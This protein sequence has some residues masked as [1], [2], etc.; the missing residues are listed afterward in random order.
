MDSKFI[1][2]QI[3]LRGEEKAKKWI[4]NLQQLIKKYEQ[5]WDIKLDRPFPNLSFNFVAGVK[6]SNGVDAVLKIGYPGDKL[7]LAEAETLKIYNGVGSIKLLKENLEDLVLL[8]ER[9]IPGDSLDSLNDEDQETLIYTQL[10]KKIWKKAPV[11]SSFRNIS[12]ELGDFDWYFENYDIGKNIIDKQ[13]V[14]KAQEKFKH[15]ITTQ[16]D[17]VLLHSDLHHDHI[18]LSKRGWLTIDCRGAIGEKEYESSHFIRNPVK[19]AEKSMITEDI[20][21]KRVDIIVRELNLDRQ[22]VIDWAF[23]QTVLSVIWSLQDTGSGA[24]YWVEI[25]KEIERIG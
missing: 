9:C 13:L 20:I 3:K 12:E 22:R 15:L 19:R 17:L 4:D 5:E 10:C 14:R 11:N 7:F 1:E 25:A 16:K 2:T 23:A 6:D 18:L 21:T 8:L 24:K